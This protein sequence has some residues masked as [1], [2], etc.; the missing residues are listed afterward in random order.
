MVNVVWLLVQASETVTAPSPGEQISQFMDTT[1][2]LAWVL[3]ILLF[4]GGLLQSVDAVK[5]YSDKILRVFGQRR[6]QK[7]EITDEQRQKLRRQLIG[8]VLRQVVKRLEDSLHHKIRLDLKRKEELERVGQ[9]T[10]TPITDSAPSDQFIHREFNPFDSPSPS[11]PIGSDISTYDL[12]ARDDIRGRLLIL[13][14]PGA[15]KTN[16]LLAVAKALLQAA[17]QSTDQPIP[18]IFEL[19]EW[20]SDNEKTFADWL[21]DQL[22]EKY[23]VSPNVSKQWIEQNQLFPL[24]DGLD[25]LRR[26]DAAETATS[27]EVDRNRQAKQT[28]CMRAINEFLDVH[29]AMSIVVCCRRKEYGALQTQGEYLKRLNG[30]IYLQELDDD[31]IQSYFKVSNREHLWD[32][33]KNQPM[34]L[35]LARSPLF[36]LMFVVAYQ[37]QPIQTIDELL[38]LYI[39]KQLGDLNNQGTY[40][41][42]KSPSAEKTHHYLS[43][44]ANRMERLSATE[45]LIEEMQPSWLSPT[46]QR[47]YKIFFGLIV[48]LISGLLFGAVFGEH[49][50]IFGLLF[51]LGYGYNIELNSAIKPADKIVWLTHRSLGGGVFNGVRDGLLF[52]LAIGSINIL[53]KGLPGGLN[54][55]FNGLLN[56]MLVG[57]LNGLHCGLTSLN[58]EGKSVPNQGVRKSLQTFLILFLF[59]QIVFVLFDAL[60]LTLFTGQPI[61]LRSG[62]FFVPFIGLIFLIFGGFN[63]GPGVIIQ[64]YTLRLLLAKEG[65]FPWDCVRFLDHAVKH[66]FIQ[67]VGGRYRFM[68]DLLRKNFAYGELPS[69]TS[70]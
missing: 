56:G 20:S 6:P 30:A 46:Y 21:S 58:I 69:H 4:V 41:P 28:Q 24:L 23:N 38:D 7:R 52:G 31:Q 32:T 1:P 2:V 62:L 5:S 54:G 39:E 29:P 17:Q 49:G 22:K 60:L 34:L 11:A 63:L 35:E 37:G 68:H 16:E 53:L 48:G 8:V 18:V 36:L 12:L 26:V 67:R 59:A 44:L 47:L 45:Y 43:W 66:R 55:L 13:G 61:N 10:P 42:G 9:H 25:E 40:P 3:A 33:L 57:L 27:E 14:E 70:R 51:G 19:S 15:G 50:L 64:H 65:S